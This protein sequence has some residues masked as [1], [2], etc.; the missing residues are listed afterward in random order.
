MNY[1]NMTME[2]LV[3]EAEALNNPLLQEMA[4][5]LSSIPAAVHTLDL[6]ELTKI[7]QLMTD[8]G[9][10]ADDIVNDYLNYD[11]DLS[12]F[13]SREWF[14][15]WD[16]DNRNDLDLKDPERAARL[17]EA[18]QDG[19]DGSTHGEHIGDMRRAVA[20]AEKDGY[21]GPLTRARLDAE[22]QGLYEWFENRGEL[23][24]QVG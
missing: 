14:N 20:D 2:E 23:D 15:S 10:T 1:R 16:A 21:I 3:R 5:R 6:T 4:R 7:D 24:R 13:L 19:I 9:L 11:T 12:E 18:A 22:I 17:Y 8:E